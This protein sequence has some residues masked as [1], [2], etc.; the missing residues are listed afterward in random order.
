MEGEELEAV[1]R[2]YLQTAA[3][4]GIL[5]EGWE[6]PEEVDPEYLVYYYHSYQFNLTGQGM[7]DDELYLEYPAAELE[8]AVQQYFDVSAEHLRTAK[9]YDAERQVYVYAV[10]AGYYSGYEAVG[11][12]RS[13]DLLAVEFVRR[14]SRS[15]QISQQG[16]VTLRLEGDGCRYLSCQSKTLLE[17]PNPYAGPL[18]PDDYEQVAERLVRPVAS[19][20][21]FNE[22]WDDPAEIPTDRLL[23]YYKFYQLTLPE[24]EREIDSLVVPAEQVE[25]FLAQAFGVSAE[26]LRTDESYRDDLGVYLYGEGIDPA[27][28]KVTGVRRDGDK[29]VVEFECL[30]NRQ[31]ADLV[32]K[33]GELTLRLTGEQYQYLSC[34]VE[35]TLAKQLTYPA[36]IGA[37]WTESG[38]TME[39]HG[40]ETMISSPGEAGY[41]V[42]KG[43]ELESIAAFYEACLGEIGAAGSTEQGKDAGS[44]HWAGATADGS[45]LDIRIVPVAGEETFSI[46]ITGEEIAACRLAA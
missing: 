36:A 37:A 43:T 20:A 10:G 14:D 34:R 40:G 26:Y 18:D 6:S 19:C 35:E 44:W 46:T 22:S 2:D 28:V 7:N 4:R 8:A 33:T 21:M 42:Y 1:W 39:T 27:P 17:S 31:L 38:V 24:D 25:R 15:D 3:H 32:T 23:H 5:K 11:A 9:R 45:P 12:S 16:T 41:A 13:G 30:F 29:L